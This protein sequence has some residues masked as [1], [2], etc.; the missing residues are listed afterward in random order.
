VR[1]Q[2]GLPPLRRLFRSNLGYVGRTM[3]AV[4]SAYA[5]SRPARLLGSL[6]AFCISAGAALGLRY[7]YL[8]NRGEEPDTFNPSFCAPY[9][10]SLACTSGPWESSLIC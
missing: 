3:L 4:L 9:A 7:H 1:E 6:S 8:M 5:I 2:I 10:R